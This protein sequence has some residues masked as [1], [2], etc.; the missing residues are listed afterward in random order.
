MLLAGMLNALI[1][2]TQAAGS[3]CLFYTYLYGFMIPFCRLSQHKFNDDS[4]PGIERTGSYSFLICPISL[5]ILSL[6]L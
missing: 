5:I 3:R 2:L 6:R 1:F 4:T